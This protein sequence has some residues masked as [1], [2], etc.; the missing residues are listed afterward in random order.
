MATFISEFGRKLVAGPRLMLVPSAVVASVSNQTV[1]AKLQV[2][3]GLETPLKVDSLGNVTA[4]NPDQPR[5]K[6]GKFGSG[7]GEVQYNLSD[8]VNRSSAKKLE[9]STWEKHKNWKQQAYGGVI[10]NS[11]NRFLLRE[12]SNHFDGV[13]ARYQGHLF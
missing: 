7:S 8:G 5:D 3:L 12:P 6:D 9:D 13:V 11:K 4:Y 1:L 2:R 10:V